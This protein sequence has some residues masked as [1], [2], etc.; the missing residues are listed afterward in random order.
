MPIDFIAALLPT[1]D[2]AGHHDALLANCFAQSEAFMKGKTAEEVRAELTAQ[3]L[4]EAKID[5]L[6]PHRTFPGNRPSNTILM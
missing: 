5:E 4:P 3:G 6:V 1:H 2:L